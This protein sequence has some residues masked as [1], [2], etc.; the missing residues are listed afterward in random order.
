MK[1]ELPNEGLGERKEPDAEAEA[2]WKRGPVVGKQEKGGCIGGG[3][4]LAEQ[5]S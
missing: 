1:P 3:V 4:G 5:A 2:P